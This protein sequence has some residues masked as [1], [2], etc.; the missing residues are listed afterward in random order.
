LIKD[1]VVFFLRTVKSRLCPCSQEENNHGPWGLLVFSNRF[2][3]ESHNMEGSFVLLF[4]N[5]NFLINKVID[6]CSP[7][8][9]AWETPCPL[10]SAWG[11]SQWPNKPFGRVIGRVIAFSSTR[12]DTCSRWCDRLSSVGLL[13]FF[14]FF[15]LSSQKNMSLSSFCSLFQFQSLFFWYLIFFW[16]FYRNFIC[17]QLSPSIS[18]WHIFFF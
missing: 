14:P 1:I 12:C 13:F 8:V 4:R 17:F 2:Y 5:I 3:C 10:S 6:A 15:S 9:S 16:S 18:I 11:I 7:C